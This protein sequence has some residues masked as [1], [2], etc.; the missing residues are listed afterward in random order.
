MKLTAE[1][2][3]LLWE[4][5]E[6]T[7]AAVIRKAKEELKELSDELGDS[8]TLTFAATE[9]LAD[10]IIM[11]ERLARSAGFSVVSEI[12]TRKLVRTKNRMEAGYYGQV[13]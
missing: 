11:C 10:V 7:E 2:Y 5:D 12:I 9:E 6:F 1:Q 3:Q 13:L 4:T 8:E